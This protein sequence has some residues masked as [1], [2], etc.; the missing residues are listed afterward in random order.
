MDYEKLSQEHFDRQAA[1]YDSRDTFYYSREGKI[2]CRDIAQYLQNVEYSNLLDVGCGTGFLIDLLQKQRKAEYIG[3][4]LSSKMIE[5]ALSKNI[6]NASFIQGTANKLPFEDK[7]FDIVVCSQSFHHY[8]YQKEALQEALRVLRPRG[9][10]IL[11]DSGLGGFSAWFDNNILFKLLRSGDCY[12]QNR[13]SAEKQLKNA[14]FE[15]IDSRQLSWMI[16]T[17]VGRKNEARPAEFL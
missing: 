1:E 13:K 11:S 17:V 10:F 9:L 4:D 12:I 2:S 16:Y 6:P 14:G 3:L 7:S 15:I 5:V 8:P